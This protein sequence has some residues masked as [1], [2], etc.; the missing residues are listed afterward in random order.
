[1]NL[2]MNELIDYF[3]DNL[4]DYT[5]SGKVV[6]EKIGVTIF[7]IR[8]RFFPNE[9]SSKNDYTLSDFENSLRRNSD[10][11]DTELYR[12]SRYVYMTLNE[13]CQNYKND[14]FI[15]DRRTHMVI[16]IYTKRVFE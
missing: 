8:F 9:I 11:R 16:N 13:F 10:K 4:I 5:E 1:M 15:V 2:K 7:Q 12:V 6:L 3:E 14:I